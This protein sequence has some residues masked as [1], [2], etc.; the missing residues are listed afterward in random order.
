MISPMC[1]Y[2]ERSWR[3]PT[4]VSME[5]DSTGAC[6][7]STPA[8]AARSDPLSRAAAHQATQH[9]IQTD[10]RQYDRENS[11]SGERPRG[12]LPWFVVGAN[13]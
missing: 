8:S 1:D 7:E 12:E 6:C 5:L 3:H 13:T 10:H 11:E 4:S 2:V 9:T